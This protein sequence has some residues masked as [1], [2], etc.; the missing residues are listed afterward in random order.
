MNFNINQLLLTIAY[1]INFHIDYSSKILI[2]NTTALIVQNRR[3]TIFKSVQNNNTTALAV[4]LFTAQQ[5]VL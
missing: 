3:I 5:Y 1:E 2:K 4:F